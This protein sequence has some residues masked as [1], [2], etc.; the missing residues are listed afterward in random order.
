[1]RNQDKFIDSLAEIVLD[2]PRESL[3]DTIIVLPNRR[4][5][6]F[7]RRQLVNRLES[8]TWLP[9]I[10]SIEEAVSSWSGFK[11]IDN[12]DLIFELL[13]IHFSMESDNPES[14]AT[15]VPYGLQMIRDFEE[16]DNYLVDS[17]A[18][19]DF[20]SE[21]RALERWHPDGSSLSA[22]ETQYLRFFKKI[23]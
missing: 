3:K 13:K 6:L 8:S 22:Y 12:T 18:I 15:F 17:Q 11:L 2:V 1:M 4:A 20:L 7:L 23:R 16:V 10:L 19:F 5:G 9:Q 21:A 14:L